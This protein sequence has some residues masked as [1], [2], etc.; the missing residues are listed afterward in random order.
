MWFKRFEA[1]KD[2]CA[3]RRAYFD[4]TSKVV[5]W[6]WQHRKW[7][8]SAK[9]S[10]L[11]TGL[12]W[13]A[14][15]GSSDAA[16]AQ[17]PQL[18]ISKVNHRNR[19]SVNIF[20]ISIMKE[21]W[22]YK[23]I[24]V[25]Q[26]HSLFNPLK[27]QLFL[28]DARIKNFTSCFKDKRFI[29]FFF[30]RLKFNDSNRYQQDFPYLSLCGRERNFIR[31][32]DV[33]IVYTETLPIA[34]T[35]F[36]F[37]TFAGAAKILIDFRSQ[38]HSCT[39]YRTLMPGTNCWCRL[40]RRK[41]SWHQRLAAFII[42]ARSSTAQLVWYDRSWPSNSAQTSNSAGAKRNRQHILRGITHATSWTID[43]SMKLN[44]HREEENCS[45][46]II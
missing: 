30:K 11:C 20:T 26:S 19:K 45:V 17:R 4:R 13:L 32:D 14:R 18:S 38:I 27:L 42:Q 3:L 23:Y 35:L 16:T 33:P 34:G 29:Q 22:E 1:H 24:S 28:D 25:S 5:W 31:C 37:S 43:G 46:Y 6:K 10:V 39:R 9:C 12:E 7:R 40:N 15:H 41:F 21:W 8:D 44:W 2:Q 36:Q